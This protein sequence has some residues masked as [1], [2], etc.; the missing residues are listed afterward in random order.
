VDKSFGRGLYAI[1]DTA[2]IPEQRFVTAVEQA[3]LG[4]ARVIQYRDKSGNRGRRLEQALALVELAKTYRIPLIINDD[5]GLAATV[6]AAGVHLGKDDMDLAS[7]RA[8]LGDTALIGVSCYNRLELAITAAEAGTDYVA[9]GSFFPSRSKPE[10]VRAD[11]ELLREARRILR[12]PIVA[13]G[14]ITPA[15]GKALVE[16]GADCLAVISGVF[17]QDDIRAAAR[18]YAAL[19]AP[20]CSRDGKHSP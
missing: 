13:I 7:A 10:A 16:A 8:R 3:M 19:Y 5:V 12:L 4:G 20:R 15:N 1:A 6:G 9:F 14:G 2:L 18:A 17:G 11:I